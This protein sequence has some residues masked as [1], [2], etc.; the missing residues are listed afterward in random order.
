MASKSGQDKY[1]GRSTHTTNQD[2]GHGRDGRHESLPVVRKP[3]SEPSAVGAGRGTRRPFEKG[4][5][6]VET[7]SSRDRHAYGRRTMDNII[8]SLGGLETQLVYGEI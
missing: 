2:Y 5:R 8:P 4:S 7:D 3:G 1:A 6:N